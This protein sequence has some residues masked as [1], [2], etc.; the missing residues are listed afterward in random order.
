MQSWLRPKMYVKFQPKKK[1]CFFLNLLITSPINFLSLF[2]FHI[3]I[4]V[5]K[6]LHKYALKSIHNVN[7]LNQTIISGKSN[8][9]TVKSSLEH[10]TTCYVWITSVQDLHG[11]G[12]ISQ[13]LAR[14]FMC[15]S[16]PVSQQT[17][18]MKQITWYPSKVT[19]NL[20]NGT[21]TTQQKREGEKK[22]PKITSTTL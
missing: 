18:R 3:T 15:Y 9:L 20:I 6:N 8:D 4:L 11:T 1:L 7:K 12:I 10:D 21:K 2:Y 17:K 19:L 14:I 13:T 5:D 22:Q 16:I